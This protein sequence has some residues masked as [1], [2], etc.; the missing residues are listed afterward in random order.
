MLSKLVALLTVVIL[1]IAIIQVVRKKHEPAPGVS[2]Q[3]VLP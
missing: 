1:S 2:T 3:Q